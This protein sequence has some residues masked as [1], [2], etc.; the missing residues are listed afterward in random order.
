MYL[1]VLNWDDRYSLNS[2]M[3]DNSCNLTYLQSLLSHRDSGTHG[4]HPNHDPNQMQMAHETN[5][6][7]IDTMATG[8][9]EGMFL[10]RVSKETCFL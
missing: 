8:V 6:S 5:W 1:N 7:N 2:T 4:M 10:E 3:L 9:G